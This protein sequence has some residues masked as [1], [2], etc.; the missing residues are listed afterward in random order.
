[1]RHS[2]LMD[3]M[4]HNQVM[5]VLVPKG[6]SIQ[7]L[8][9]EPLPNC[10]GPADSGVAAPYFFIEEFLT[11]CQSYLLSGGDW[12]KYARDFEK[13]CELVNVNMRRDIINHK[14][15]RT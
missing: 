5:K 9:S 13:G 2:Q 10:A 4:V 1:M 14:E 8:S 15:V 3:T 11:D 12:I 6:R 7:Y